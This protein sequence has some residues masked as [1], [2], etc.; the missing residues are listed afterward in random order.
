MRKGRFILGLAIAF[1]VQSGI[2]GAM[3][4]S[5]ISVLRGGQ[6]I[7]IR[8]TFVDPRDIFRGHYVRLNLTVD[9]PDGDVPGYSD[10]LGADG[11]A[12]VTL[13]E[14]EGGFWVA[15]ALHENMPTDTTDPIL[16]IAGVARLRGQED[17]V[18]IA[19]PFDRYFAD[20]ERAQALEKLRRE[21][22][23]GVL[24]ALDGTGGG[25]IK[26]LT[27]DG[28]RVYDELLY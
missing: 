22:K 7:A 8:S 10:D 13:R 25:V 1:A 15:K 28:E 24:L 19:L 2:V 6:E 27:I 20:F 16:Q 18:R 14:G 26:G 17:A 23:L 11:T 3:V 5:R 4:W 9:P 12:Y 21:Q